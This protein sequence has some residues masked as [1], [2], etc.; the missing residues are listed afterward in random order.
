MVALVLHFMEKIIAMNKNF[1]IKLKK[2]K[3]KVKIKQV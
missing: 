3:N 1:I 2:K